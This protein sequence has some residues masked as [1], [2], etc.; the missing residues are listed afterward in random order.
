MFL[1]DFNLSKDQDKKVPQLK[2]LEIIMKL[3]NAIGVDIHRK[4]M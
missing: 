2:L 3:L 1:V 4:D